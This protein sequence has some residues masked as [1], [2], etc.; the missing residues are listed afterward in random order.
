[1]NASERSNAEG[2]TG[3]GSAELDLSVEGGMDDKNPPELRVLRRP[4][5]GPTCEPEVVANLGQPDTADSERAADGN[6]RGM[7]GLTARLRRRPRRV[8]EGGTQ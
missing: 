5:A 3:I 4:T 1:M 8:R 2:I 6:G 7:R